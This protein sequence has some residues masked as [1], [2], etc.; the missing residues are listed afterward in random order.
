M[1]KITY[2]VAILVLRRYSLVAIVRAGWDINITI[3]GHDNT[4]FTL[5]NFESNFYCFVVLPFETVEEALDSLKRGVAKDEELDLIV[6]EVH[7]G[8]TELGT[9]VLFYHI[10]NELEVPLISKH[11]Y[12]ELYCFKKNFFHPKLINLGVLFLG[13]SYVCL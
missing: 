6:A 4:V 3:F 10:L 2:Q 8:N 11:L 1:R 12:S 13:C 5:Q 7:P 9:L